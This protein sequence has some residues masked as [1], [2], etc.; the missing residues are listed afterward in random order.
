[1][2]PK[3]IR[4]QVREMVGRMIIESTSLRQRVIRMVMRKLSQVSYPEKKRFAGFKPTLIAAL[5]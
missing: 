4:V 1:M 2:R 5:W 3:V